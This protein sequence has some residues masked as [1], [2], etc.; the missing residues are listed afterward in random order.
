MKNR[1][2]IL[3]SFINIDRPFSEVSRDLFE[4]DWNWN[5][6]K[7][8]VINRVILISILHRYL[9]GELNASILQRWSWALLGRED[10]DYEKGYRNTILDTLQYLEE[11]IPEHNLALPPEQAQIL[12]HRLQT[13][14]FDPNDD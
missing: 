6:N 10:I 5:E 4:V 9:K 8:A 14:P 2:Q 13:A 7:L 12:I 11:A 3:E 1:K